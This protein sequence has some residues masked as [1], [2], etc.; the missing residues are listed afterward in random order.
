M[1]ITV[2]LLC[3]AS[4]LTAQENSLLPIGSVKS[5]SKIEPMILLYWRMFR[6]QNRSTSPKGCPKATQVVASHSQELRWKQ[7]MIIS[8][9]W[10]CCSLFTLTETFV[11]FLTPTTTKKRSVVPKHSNGEGYIKGKIVK[12]DHGQEELF[13]IRFSIQIDEIDGQSKHTIKWHIWT[14]V[15]F[16]LF[17]VLNCFNPIRLI[18]MLIVSLSLG[19]LKSLS[20]LFLPLFLPL[21]LSRLVSQSLSRISIS[22]V[23]YLN[24]SVS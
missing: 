16:V 13:R 9:C 4:V 20:L 22:L 5:S 7:R 2:T 19:N 3:V 10:F 21:S 1:R 8:F 6:C 11:L 23:S 12:T 18:T 24:L 14:V 17:T 15:I